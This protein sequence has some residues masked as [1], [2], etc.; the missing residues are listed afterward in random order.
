MKL[1]AMGR[2]SSLMV[3][4]LLLSAAV[5]SARD[6]GNEIVIGWN[7]LGMHCMNRYFNHLCILPPYNTVWSQAIQ[8]GTATTLPVILQS[9]ITI[10]YA[11]AE[12]TYSVG[13]TDFWDHEDQLFGVSLPDNIGLT[14]RG[15]TGN[16]TN[17]GTY[18][19]AEG[20]PITPFNDSNWAVEA[21]FQLMDLTLRNTLGDILDSG[22]IVV[23]V[24]TEIHCDSCHTG[25][26]GSEV[27]ILTLHDEENDT[28]LVGSQPVLCAGCHA[29]NALGAPGQPG[30]PN[31]SL[32]MHGKHAEENV[33]AIPV[34]P[35]SARSAF[36]GFTG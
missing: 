23:P 15:L 6:L 9:G 18:W 26:Q 29:D 20:I 21:P 11:F 14:G 35:G 27:A 13:K 36:A 16:L 1:I 30:H 8:R 17:S 2:L 7:D 24:S 4:I 12:N 28:N 34:I 32:A 3:C 19:I 10:D 5:S 31:F 22:Q 25:P 33:T